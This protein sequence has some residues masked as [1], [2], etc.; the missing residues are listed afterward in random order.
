MKRLLSVGLILG[1]VVA[2]LSATAAPRTDIST[3]VGF[4]V[5]NCILSSEKASLE[6]LC[7]GYVHAVADTLLLEKAGYYGKRKYCLAAGRENEVASHLA[8][9][10]RET[11]RVSDL[12]TDESIAFE[13]IKSDLKDALD[14]ETGELS[15]DR[16]G[17]QASAFSD[18]SITDRKL[19]RNCL[20]ADGTDQKLFCYS[21]LTGVMD[22][23]AD[24]KG[25]DGAPVFCFD[26]K[27]NLEIA[28][29]IAENLDMTLTLD[30]LATLD[31]PSI[32][33]IRSIFSALTDC[34]DGLLKDR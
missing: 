13:A 9:H 17:M 31:A 21:Y 14:C 32:H 27:R 18:A 19:L 8:N 26:R 1:G 29:R 6:A 20:A 12:T 7:Y 30:E 2:A 33:N 25:K 4:V 5:G 28:V 3:S 11:R 16:Y 10:Y 24:V 22:S 23:L 34:Q 15:R